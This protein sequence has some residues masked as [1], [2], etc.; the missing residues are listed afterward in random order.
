MIMPTARDEGRGL[1]GGW[2]RGHPGR[3]VLTSDAER[4][5]HRE[6]AGGTPAAGQSRKMLYQLSPE[7]QGVCTC[8]CVRAHTHARTRTQQSRRPRAPHCAARH[9]GQRWTQGSRSSG[10]AF[11]KSK[12]PPRSWAPWEFCDVWNGL[13]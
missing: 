5:W 9:H 1:A 7:R 8:V 4:P 2:K 3:G 13:K 10:P 12:A 11:P 6:Q